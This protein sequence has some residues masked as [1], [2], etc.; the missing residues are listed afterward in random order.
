[1]L[2]ISFI[3]PDISIRSPG[4]IPSMR[5][6]VSSFGSNSALTF[7]SPKTEYFAVMWHEIATM[8]F[9]PNEYRSESVPFT[10]TRFPM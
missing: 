7:F 8:N 6:T 1:M 9:D 10:M 2:D 3:F 4:F 5:T